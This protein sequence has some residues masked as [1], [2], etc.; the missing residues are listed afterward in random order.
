VH[1]NGG[2]E[3]YDRG[4]KKRRPLHINKLRTSFLPKDLGDGKK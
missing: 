3:V 4:R 1:E 2:E